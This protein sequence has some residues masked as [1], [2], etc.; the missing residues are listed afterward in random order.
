MADFT[1]RSNVKAVLRVPAGVTRHDALIDLYVA[2]IDAEMLSLLG[3]SGYTSQSYSEVYDIDGPR[4]N[5]IQLR[6]WPATSVAAVTD[7]GSAVA[8]TDYYVD[9]ETRSFLRLKGSGSFFTEGRQK[10]AITYTAGQAIPG[11]LTTAATL[12]VAHK[13]N[14][15]GH[16]G[17]ASEIGGGYH[18][19]LATGEAAYAPPSVMA[20][21]NRKRALLR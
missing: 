16:V 17:Y 19:T 14:S 7:D 20:I 2:G 9:P 1:T 8:A 21:I 12:L 5:A 15:G 18:Y 6:H 11:D 4:E 3:V 10:V 13:V